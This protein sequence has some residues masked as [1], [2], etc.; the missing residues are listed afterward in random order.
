MHILGLGVKPRFGF[1][2]FPSEPCF[3]GSR[4]TKE[5]IVL[6]IQKILVDMLKALEIEE[7]RMAS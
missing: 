4:K 3:F 6:H 1:A 7:Q 2:H 5:E